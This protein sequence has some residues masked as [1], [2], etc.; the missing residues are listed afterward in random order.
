MTL[1]CLGQVFNPLALL[2]Y[3]ALPSATLAIL[4]WYVILLLRAFE[5]NPT[6][7]PPILS[8]GINGGGSDHH[9]L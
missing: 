6:I 5:L 2:I 3:V 9:S 8:M 1:S 4:L 7:F